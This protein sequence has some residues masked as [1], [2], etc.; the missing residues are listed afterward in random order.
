MKNPGEKFQAAKRA[1]CTKCGSRRARRSIQ[2]DKPCTRCG[3][4][5]GGDN[6]PHVSETHGGTYY[7][8]EPGR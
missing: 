4:V 2:A 6:T 1:T 8:Q 5:E 3:Y 7:T